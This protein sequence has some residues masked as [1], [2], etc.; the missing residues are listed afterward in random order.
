MDNYENLKGDQLIEKIRTINM[1]DSSFCGGE[2]GMEVTY[3]IINK[4]INK[5][6]QNGVM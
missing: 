1:I 6:N 3:R 4:V 2:K 5:I